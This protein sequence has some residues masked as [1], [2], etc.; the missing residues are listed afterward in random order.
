MSVGAVDNSVAK[1][2]HAGDLIEDR[3][4][5]SV[6]DDRLAH[7]GI[8]DQLVALVTTV[9]T[10][11]NIALYGPWG[12]G[13]SGIANLL[14]A[15]IDGSEGRTFVRFDAFKY[16]DVPLRRN[17]ISAI[18]SELG[19]TESKF[20]GDLYTGRTKTE[21][22]IPAYRVAKLLG[23]FALLMLGLTALIG[24][25]LAVVAWM[26]SGDFATEYRALLK[27]AVMAGLLPAS[28]LAAMISLASKTFNIERSL[29][30]PESDEQFEKLFKD[31]VDE[32]KAKRL[33]IFVD[34]LDRCSPDEVVATLDTVRTFL[35]LDRCVFVIAADQNVLERALT[36]RAKQATPSDEANPYYSTGSAYLDKVFQ[37]QVA[38]PPLLAQ[39]VSSFAQGLVKGRQGVWAEIE[40]EYVLSVLIPTH[41][42]SPR[43]VKHLLNTFA[44]TYRLAE[45]RYSANLLSVHPKDCAAAI[46][47]LVCLRVEFPLFA[48]HLEIDSRL[49][50][51]V[52]RLTRRP[53]VGLPPGVSE[54]AEELAR[55]YAIGGAAPASML[56]PDEPADGAGDD[57]PDPPDA[58]AV[59][60]VGS[61]ERTI[62]AHNKQ[63]LNYLS[64]TRQ[65]RGPDRDLVYM[66]TTGTGF[67][68]D[69]G[70]ALAI[71]QAAEDGDL[72]TLVQRVA[73]LPVADQAAVL[74]LLAEQIRAGDALTGPNTAHS[75]LMLVSAVPGLPVER[76]LDTVIAAISRFHDDGSSV[77]DGDSIGSAWALARSRPGP[78]A[79]LLRR[80]LVT[81][82]LGDGG[83][84]IDFL[85]RDAALAIAANQDLADHIEVLLTSQSS[86]EAIQ[87]LF[88]A[89]DGDLIKVF[90]GLHTGLVDRVSGYL[91]R[92]D[93]WEKDSSAASPVAR[94]AAPTPEPVDVKG[95]FPALVTAA[96]GRET[97]VQ[98][99]VLRFL[100]AVD[101]K[102]ARD[103]AGDLIAKT[104]PTGEPD[105]AGAVLRGLAHR[106]LVAVPRWLEG[107]QVDAIRAEHAG[108]LTRILSVLVEPNQK[109]ADVEPAFSALRPYIDALPESARPDLTGTLVAPLEKSVATSEEAEIRSRQLGVA[110]LLSRRGL[111][112]DERVAAAVVSTLA[113]ALAQPLSPVGSDDPLYR[114]VVEDG[115]GALRR[116]I[117]S[118]DESQVSKIV[119]AATSGPWLDTVARI[120]VSMRLMA[121]A[122][123]EGAAPMGLPTAAEILTLVTNYGATA[124]PSAA[125]WVELAVPGPND[126][127][128]VLDQLLLEG[129]LSGPFVDAAREVERTW[130]A[131]EHRL[132]LDRYLKDPVAEL[133]A[134]I[135]LRA[136]GLAEA[137]ENQVAEL[138]CT[139]FAGVSN[140]AQRRM[141]VTLWSRAD[142]REDA[143]RKR[144]IETVV[145]GLLRLHRAD[146]GNAG[147]VDLALSALDT[148]GS[149][150]PHG[151]K[152]TLGQHVQAAVAGDEVLAR[153]AGRVLSRIGIPAK[154]KGILGRLSRIDLGQ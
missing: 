36:R 114:Y 94:V 144:L 25:V 150:L 37:Y 31:L 151:L 101:H 107:I 124:V 137:P 120:E 42:A 90:S 14:K 54:R 117:G 5:G 66:Q 131:D 35:G 23:L 149:P 41:V 17:F 104:E 98:H 72:A 26:Q 135:E 19:C 78:G 86:T 21:I 65:V 133:P 93:T 96:S 102:A 70:L 106:G 33:V 138:L 9:P 40:T 128:L 7:A 80:Q 13:K 136:L 123:A 77:L 129:T 56:A 67:G 132:L 142:L 49:P 73:D 153:K 103:A 119:D 91:R 59:E 108:P 88:G 68:L 64:R 53:P 63:L 109:L 20:H 100:L 57:E 52:L 95:L 51:L 30:K 12:S 62:E 60:E 69:G 154:S 29:A 118:T 121:A 79:E 6:E 24:V 122:T 3:E 113:S 89:E 83:L 28:L 71:E 55:A 125:L 92:H 111:V 8:V 47:R 139:R 87:T 147:A 50:D 127:A 4:L 75:F 84:S 82:A 34:E 16:A 39:R 130:S 48:R 134:D 140:N 74:D 58:D 110:R 81:A 146:K 116:A 143:A 22:E 85:L 46:A 61:R 99:A 141:V 148:M 15:R 112:D 10:P 2:L 27:Q 145:L 105:L 152:G 76:V 38:L 43:R 115:A 11:S 97:P 1:V 32:S 18:A 44:L 45:Q 126:L